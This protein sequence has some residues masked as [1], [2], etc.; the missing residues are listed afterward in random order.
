[1]NASTAAKSLE[2]GVLDGM[3][4][5][6]SVGVGIL[7][8]GGV[9]GILEECRGLSCQMFQGRLVLGRTKG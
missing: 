1:M 9:G 5:F 4:G 8:L 3:N 7:G 6:G 2:I